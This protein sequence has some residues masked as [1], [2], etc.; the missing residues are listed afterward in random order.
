MCGVVTRGLQQWCVDVA[1]ECSL[2][3][4]SGCWMSTA[5]H[6][7]QVLQKLWSK[8]GQLQEPEKFDDQY[9]FSESVTECL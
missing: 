1:H 2:C 5:G 7:M 9:M 3:V 6:A 4:N 8:F